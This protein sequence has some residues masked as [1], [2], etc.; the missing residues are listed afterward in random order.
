MADHISVG[1][2]SP[3]RGTHRQEESMPTP[4]R[5]AAFRCFAQMPA[6]TNVRR[7]CFA[8][9]TM[10]PAEKKDRRAARHEVEAALKRV[11]VRKLGLYS[12]KAQIKAGLKIL[13]DRY[14]AEQVR[15]AAQRI[16][17]QVLAG[18][19]AAPAPTEPEQVHG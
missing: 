4:A 19:S 14:Y 11:A 1:Y 7:L 17:E 16:E 5:H 12:T 6:T 18:Q 9:D 10:T 3:V 8:H 2:E 15:P 13:C